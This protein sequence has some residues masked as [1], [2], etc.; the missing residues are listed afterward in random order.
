MKEW[1]KAAE[2][3]RILRYMESFLRLAET[4][5]DMPTGKEHL[6]RED[7]DDIYDTVRQ[8]MCAD[9]GRREGCWKQNSRKTW[10]MIYDMLVAVEAGE[11]TLTEAERQ[12]YRYCIRGKA[13][14]EELKNSFGRAK[15]NLLWSNR[16]M[17]NRAA[18]AEQLMETAQIMKEIAC[19]VFDGAE[20][21]MELQKK[22]RLRMK[23]NGIKILEVRTLPNGWGHPK[24]AVTMHSVRG[25]CVS[26]KA[27]SAVLSELCGR[28]MVPERDS[29]MTVGREECT[30]HFVEDTHYYMLTGMA[31]MPCK[32]QVS[33]GDNFG[34]LT[35][36]HGRVV[37][38]L[39]D[40][41]GTGSEAGRESQE[42]IELLEQ[43]LDAGFTVETAVK[44]IN[45]SMV[46]QRGM[47]Q[48]STLDICSVNLYNGQCRLMKVGASTTFIRRDGWVE[49][50]I[51]QSL[52]VGV[53]QKI[54]FESVEKK[55]KHGDVIVMM[56]DGALDALPQEE[57]EELM[58]YLILHTDT[59]NPSE[60]AHLLL[61]QILEF[62]PDG[63]KDDIT[64]LAG[65]FFQK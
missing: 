44:M 5:Q 17:E 60:L 46:L 57:G 12:F 47:R 18:V 28:T 64:I 4:F 6:S 32:D 1:I 63:A 24:M 22:L 48:Y 42:V 50:V 45:S 58:K 37:M 35:G 34:F 40:G 29:R 26:V 51:S 59:A 62:Q 13:F 9:C 38:S 27:V 39:S 7:M 8:I 31:G 10:N 56:S 43:F 15:L 49:S 33:S 41:M 65:G 3:D 55:L 20:A 23:P 19:T 25:H 14:K 36:S 61:K 21:E 2:K 30:V 54:D 52:P 11:E 53:L 16:M